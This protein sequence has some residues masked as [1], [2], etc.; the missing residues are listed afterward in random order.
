MPGAAPYH[1]APV[2]LFP[3]T[4]SCRAR[5]LLA[6]V[7]VVASLAGCRPTSEKI[8]RWKET[9]AGPRKLA[10][11]VAD[12]ELA[13]P[14]RG[15][16][17]LALIEIR[18][19]E[20]LVE[21]VRGTSP[22]AQ[23][24]LMT[25]LAQTLLARLEGSAAPAARPTAIEAKDALFALREWIPAAAR[26]LADEGLIRWLVADWVGRSAGDHSGAKI[27]RAIGGAAAPVL[28]EG[29]R[30]AE[31]GVAV[32]FAQLLRELGSGADRERAAALLIER[33][34]ERDGL[35]REAGYQALAA[36]ASPLGRSHLLA[37]AQSGAT[38]DRVLALLALAKAP[39][40]ASLPAL[41]ALAGG[42][43]IP[44]AVREAAF[45]ALEAVAAPATAD[46]L[47]AILARDADEKVRYRAVEALVA[48]CGAAGAERLLAALPPGYSYRRLDVSDFVERDLKDIG[49]AVVPVLRRALASPSWIARV[50]AVRVLGELGSEADVAALRT[51]L[52][53]QTPLRGWQ[54]GDAAS[55][56]GGATVAAEAR[57]AIERLG[58]ARHEPGHEPGREP[59]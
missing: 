4:R 10:A 54:G 26:G 31:A 36:L 58:A 17:A 49:A 43:R 53:D 55:R 2:W 11:A 5:A 56:A 20:A 30:R 51:L 47:A 8:Q 22:A 13:L 50:I 12:A 46:V 34:R 27:A 1:R 48:C 15:E 59:R 39:A 14:L 28:A 3:P 23:G 57:A 29:L 7:A 52:T 21:A 38:S 32:V 16:A 6:S 35:A 9:E 45:T 24:A 41:G 37:A 18:E 33:L 19:L 25:A 42:P 40:V 44:A